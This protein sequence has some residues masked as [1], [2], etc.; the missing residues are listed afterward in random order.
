MWFWRKRATALPAAQQ[1]RSAS[2]AVI[3]GLERRCL[4]SI[5][6]VS[7]D[8]GDYVAPQQNGSAPPT[9]GSMVENVSGFNGTFSFELQASDGE[10]GDQGGGFSFDPNCR[11]IR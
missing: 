5:T 7:V 4:M 2:R 11:R 9:G 8:T 10:L 6:A 1:V 3:E